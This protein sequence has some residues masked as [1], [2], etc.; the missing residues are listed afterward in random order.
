M[1]PPPNSIAP[2]AE[3]SRRRHP[4]VEEKPL[5]GRRRALVIVVVA[6]ATDCADN[7]QTRVAS[8]LCGTLTITKAYP[9]GSLPAVSDSASAGIVLFRISFKSSN[10]ASI[11]D[12]ISELNLPHC[13]IAVSSIHTPLRVELNARRRPKRALQATRANCMAY[14]KICSLVR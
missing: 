12:S 5:L 14:L 3:M 2:R 7:T 6:D 4:R 8:G 13:S 11:S 1:A 10:Q 9:R